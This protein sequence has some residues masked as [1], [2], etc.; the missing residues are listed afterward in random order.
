MKGRNTFITRLPGI[1]RL[2]GDG[3]VAPGNR[4]AWRI[5]DPRPSAFPTLSST[6]YLQFGLPVLHCGQRGRRPL[7]LRLVLTACL[8]VACGSD[9]RGQ[10]YA[11][12]DPNNESRPAISAVYGELNGKIESVGPDTFMLLDS[13][14]KPQPVLNMSIDQFM[15]AWKD[16]QA[17]AAAASSVDSPFRLDECRMVSSIEGNHVS[18]ET[19]VDLTLDQDGTTDVPLSFAGALLKK[20]PEAPEEH[21]GVYVWYDAGRGGYYVRLSGKTGDK[22]T[23]QLNLIVPI[24]RDGARATLKLLAP[25]ATKSSLLLVSKNSVQSVIASEGVLL[26]TTEL[27][28]GGTRIQA[29]GV[30]GETSVSWM[31]RPAEKDRTDSVL[32][33]SVRSL[34]SIDGREIRTNARITVEGFGQSFREFTVRLPAGSRYVPSGFT[35]PIESIEEV[36]DATASGEE[37]GDASPQ[38]PE[39]RVTL[40]A[41]QTDQVSIDLQ[42]IEPVPTHG[43]DTRLELTSFEVVDALPQDGEVALLVDDAWQLRWVS[44]NSIRLIDQSQFDLSWMANPPASKDLTAALRFARQPWSLPVILAPRQ[45]KVVATPSYELTI[46]PGEALLRMEVDYSI[47]GGQALPVAFTPRFSLVGWDHLQTTTVNLEGTQ[48]EG[49]QNLSTFSDPDAEAQPSPGYFGFST[50]FATS[51]NPK[52]VLEFRRV[53]EPNESEFFSLE[54]PYPDHEPLVI[55]PGI[56]VVD[57][58]T[59]L[60]LA[61]D[62]KRNIGLAALPVEASDEADMGVSPGQ[63]FRY[64][65][66]YPRLTFAAARQS[67][68][69]R[70]IVS[71]EINADVSLD[72]FQVSQTLDIDVR[73][74]AAS[75]ILIATPGSAS[76]W[77]FE[78]LPPANFIG[79]DSEVGSELEVAPLVGEPSAGSASIPEKRLLLP[80]PRLGKFRIRASYTLPASPNSGGSRLLRLISVPDAEF[81]GHTVKL[82]SSQGQALTTPANSQWRRLPA[83]ENGGARSDASVFATASPT[84]FLLLEQGGQLPALNLVD[85]DRVW[86]QTWLTARTMQ[87]RVAFRFRGDAEQLRIELP[88]NTPAGNDFE[89]VLDGA[90]LS[91]WSRDKGAIVVDAPRNSTDDQRTLELRY[92][93]PCTLGWQVPLT[94]DRPRLVGRESSADLLYWQIITPVQY[95]PLQSAAALVDA[96]QTRWAT[97]HWRVVSELDTAGLERWVG[98]TEGLR[99]SRG[100]QSVLY[101]AW[102][103]AMLETTLVRRELLVLVT[104]AVVL[105]ACLALFYLP[106]LRQMP[107]SLIL[108]ATIATAGLAAPQVV[109]VVAPLGLYGLVCVIAGWILYL[110]FGGRQ[111]ATS[112]SSVS[113]S[114]RTDASGSH[115]QSTLLPLQAGSVSTNAPTVSVELTDSNV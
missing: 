60:Q 75:S 115:R 78:L 98:A 108:L 40:V 112:T 15:A 4:A 38:G 59:S 35:E 34:I 58:D 101:R 82:T 33:A 13:E 110:L 80:H 62:A 77:Q 6:H 28:A 68:S 76:D 30:V 99:P 54:L 83:G 107:I 9:T 64:R 88:E 5:F 67:R 48:E 14:G 42:A 61:P 39:L 97:G 46:N 87:L 8:A 56:L 1:V 21:R 86:V 81:R 109:A 63:Q 49:Q 105:G 51:R 102:P 29:E 50:A 95:Q 96:Y 52:V 111:P 19:I 93:L 113:S 10:T 106:W 11:E 20:L 104:S 41:D 90:T 103:D 53:W 66:V 89:V 79:G 25:R 94:T 84:G 26:S 91:D 43:D 7:L 100:E 69:Q 72:G 92:R 70:L 74:Q 73:H 17:L 3:V 22:H 45:E 12:A 85:I 55:N 18:L 32:S 44:P 57:A 24:R 27:A 65:G 16:Q 23:I 47:E 114:G 37:S 2:S 71:S 31:D 36:L